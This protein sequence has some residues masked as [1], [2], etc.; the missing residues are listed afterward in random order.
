MILSWRA[1]QKTHDLP[2]NMDG[3]IICDVDCDWY[4][5]LKNAYHEKKVVL[6]AN[7]YI[8]KTR[9]LVLEYTEYHEY[10]ASYA[11]FYLESLE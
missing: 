1:K 11:D 3:H 5:F 6:Y 4:F 7:E 8:P 2:I 10:L 9:M